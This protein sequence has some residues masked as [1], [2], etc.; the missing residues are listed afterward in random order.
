MP[1]GLCNAPTAFQRC[2]MAI[3]ANLVEKCIEVFMDNFSVFGDSFDLCLKN[4]ETILESCVETNLV[5]N[6]EK[7]HF[8]VTEGIVLGHKISRKGIEVDKAKVHVIE[9]L[10]PPTN[11]KGIGSFLGHAGFYRRFIKDFS[12]TAKPLYNL[13]LKDYAF[14]FD[15]SCLEVFKNEFN[16]EICDK[17]EKDNLVAD[18]LSRLNNEEITKGE[19]EIAEAFLD[20][21]LFLLQERPCFPDIANYKASGIFPNHFNYQQKQKFLKEVN[22]YV[23]DEPYLFK[24]GTDN[25]IRRCVDS[26]EAK[27]ILW[28]CHNS[29]CGGHYNGERTAAKVIQSGKFK[30]TWS[31]PFMIKDVKQYEALELEDPKSQRTWTVN[32]QRLKPYLGDK[33]GSIIEIASE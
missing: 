16:L 3:F 15:E 25:I 11:V 17:S 29:T 21:K 5:L 22:Y 2:M 32:G 1:F 30:T 4:L 9:K 8:M 33:S 6:W 12:K 26:K 10:P 13:L 19:R 18:H 27:K 24:E 23:W 31:G 20:E 28:H 14:N 7:C